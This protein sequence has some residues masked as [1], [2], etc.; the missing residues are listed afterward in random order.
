MKPVIK[1]LSIDFLLFASASEGY[2]FDGISNNSLNLRSDSYDM[3][4][5]KRGKELLQR[6]HIK[7]GLSTATDRSR[8]SY[9]DIVDCNEYYP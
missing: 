2:E 6:S 5:S 1:I 8:I 9:I 4:A 7:Q 3:S